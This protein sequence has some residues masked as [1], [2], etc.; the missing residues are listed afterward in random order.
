MHRIPVRELNQHT[1]AV[2]TMVQQGETV[3]VTLNGRLIARILPAEPTPL[4][5]LITRGRV[6]PATSTGPIP[7]PPSEPDLMTDSTETI[8]ALREER[9]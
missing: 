4:E 5:D 7:L 9:L 2:L 3:E 6:I 8:S 1:S